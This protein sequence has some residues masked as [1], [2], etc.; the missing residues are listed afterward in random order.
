[1]SE[2]TPRKLKPRGETQNSARSVA[3][4][5]NLLQG[6]QPFGSIAPVTESGATGLLPAC[7]LHEIGR[8]LRR[9]QFWTIGG[10]HL[11]Q[12]PAPPAFHQSYNAATT[13]ALA[14]GTASCFLHIRSLFSP[15][16]RAVCAIIS[17]I[18]SSR[19]PTKD[20]PEGRAAP[21][22][23]HQLAAGA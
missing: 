8:V 2:V 1:M 9:E 16:K 21:K 22:E 4:R 5:T 19:N 6:G 11:R 10:R 15:V 18:S 20:P 13:V 17:T 23:E 7:S 3:W 12:S 14:S